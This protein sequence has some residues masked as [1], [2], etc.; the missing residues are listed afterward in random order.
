MEKKNN[1][2]SWL[3]RTVTVGIVEYF[4]GNHN[5][6]ASHS[7]ITW[8]IP[9]VPQITACTWVDSKF[10]GANMGPIWVLS[11]PDGPRVG[12]MNLAIRVDKGDKTG[13]HPLQAVH[14]PVFAHGGRHR[15][16]ATLHMTFDALVDKRS[17]D[18]NL[19]LH[20]SQLMLN[21][22]ENKV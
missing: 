8:C 16:Q 4:R 6:R 15:V 13:Y 22:L 14:S 10:H 18:A 1:S 17:P 5:C 7:I 2:L 3:C 12:P 11:V 9:H 20:L 19:G 21:Y